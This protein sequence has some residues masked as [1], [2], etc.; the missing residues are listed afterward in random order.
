LTVMEGDT[1]Q[2]VEVE[3]FISRELKRD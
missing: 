2:R 1:D 3:R